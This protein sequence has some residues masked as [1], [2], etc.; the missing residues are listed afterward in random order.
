MLQPQ[1]I[2]TSLG[3]RPER[4]GPA[5]T[6]RVIRLDDQAVFFGADLYGIPKPYLLE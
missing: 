4:F 2:V 3:Y 1:P 6:E 5:L